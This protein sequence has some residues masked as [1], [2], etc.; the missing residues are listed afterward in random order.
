MLVRPDGT[1]IVP[2]A[3]ANETAVRHRLGTDEWDQLRRDARQPPG[4]DADLRVGPRGGWL[5]VGR[6]VPGP[7]LRHGRQLHA[8][9]EVVVGEEHLRVVD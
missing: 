2:I 8:G 5:R 7:V 1:V 3:N 6:S 4:A 9:D